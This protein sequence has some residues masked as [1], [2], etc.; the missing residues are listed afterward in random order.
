MKI[1]SNSTDGT[2][3][4]IHD[5]NVK[6]VD[7]DF[8]LSDYQSGEITLLYASE[9]YKNRRLI[10]AVVE[11]LPPYMDCLP[12]RPKDKSDG[13]F[14]FRRSDLRV[15]LRRVHL[16][17]HDAVAWYRNCARGEVELP[18]VKW[19]KS[20]GSRPVKLGA[21]SEEPHWPNLV[22]EYPDSYFWDGSPLWGHRQGQS[23]RHSLFEISRWNPFSQLGTTDVEKLKTWLNDNLPVDLFS[24]PVLW[25]S[26]HLV[27]PNAVFSDLDM[28]ISRAEGHSI[29][30][31]LTPRPG[32]LVKGLQITVEDRRPHGP[33][34]RQEFSVEGQY[35]VLHL[36]EEPQSITVD[37]QCPRRGLLYR[38]PPA[39]FIRNISI[40][41]NMVVG[42]RIV[43]LREKTTGRDTSY[44][45]DVV[46]SS[47]SQV[48]ETE[49]PSALKTVLDDLYEQERRN[50]AEALGIQWFNKNVEEAE[51]RI[52]SLIA[53]AE[54]K[55]LIVDPY[56]GA[57]E[58]RRFGL[59]SQHPES[60]IMFLTSAMYLKNDTNA[61]ELAA[62]VI[63]IDQSDPSL[64]I[65]V[66]VM[67]GKRPEIHDRFLVLDSQVWMLGSS[68]NE[69][70]SRGTMMVRLPYPRP[71]VHKI[72]EIWDSA[73]DFDDWMKDRRSVDPS[74][75]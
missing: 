5:W 1:P 22:L 56:L 64:L 62:E 26:A 44:T 18:S 24:R 7:M 40:G 75:G 19:E 11:L 35:S 27:L 48:G 61:K 37:V 72:E 30:F 73:V 45:V 46:K 38:T 43:Q 33:S 10:F 16:T 8:L 74:E 17:P 36:P 69:F 53:M 31:D 58:L 12:E 67:P 54:K 42:Q 23:R 63:N 3:V 6:A 32:Q 39:T 28:R 57:E 25:G 4:E 14:S 68:L 29:L 60:K 21:I 9:N 2:P 34:W 65:E 70:A 15:H 47:T 20:D 51:D 41:M 66:K 13:N 59:A 50:E 49:L 55:V 52:R 71:I